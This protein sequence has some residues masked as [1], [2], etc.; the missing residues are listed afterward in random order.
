[1][2]EVTLKDYFAA[3]ALQGLLA[4]PKLAD[5]IIKH[6]GGNGS[7]IEE[8]AYAFAERMLVERERL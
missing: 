3:K 8:T 7:W 1:M 5:E 6:G 2:N 4:N